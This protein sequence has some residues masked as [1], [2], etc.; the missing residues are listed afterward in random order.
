[1]PIP[2][3]NGHDRGLTINYP[4]LFAAIY[5]LIT[6]TLWKIIFYEDFATLF[7]LLARSVPMFL[8]DTVGQTLLFGM[9]K[10]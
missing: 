4:H 10:D 2:D 6:T 1:L 3:F 9:I 8:G 5:K 7:D